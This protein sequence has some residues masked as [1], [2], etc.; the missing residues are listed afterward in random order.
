MSNILNET[1]PPYPGFVQQ[2]PQ[3]NGPSQP[4]LLSPGIPVENPPYQITIVERRYFPSLRTEYL[5]IQAITMG[6]I[7]CFCG[8]WVCSLPAMLLALIPQC[9]PN[10]VDIRY[11]TFYSTSI[12]LS[13]LA[14]ISSILLF[15][16]LSIRYSL[17]DIFYIHH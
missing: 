8:A 12:F 4:P 9:Y 5:R 6:V 3:P 17:H 11:R 15:I 10:P 2:Q 7:G 16:T 14:I 13:T 1:P